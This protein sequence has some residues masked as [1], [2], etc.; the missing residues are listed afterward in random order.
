MK[1]EGKTLENL[2]LTDQKL[3]KRSQLGGALR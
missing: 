2:P 3:H 1:P